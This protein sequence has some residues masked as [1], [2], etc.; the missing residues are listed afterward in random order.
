MLC[1]TR[2][3]TKGRF[4]SSM[5]N[6]KMKKIGL[7]SALMV[8]TAST[9]LTGCGKGNNDTKQ[10]SPTNAAESASNKNDVKKSTDAKPITL[11]IHA[12][13]DDLE[14]KYQLTETYHKSHPNVNFEFQISKDDKAQ[15]LKVK[16]VAGELPDLMFMHSGWLTNLKDYLEPLNDTAAFKQNKFAADFQLDG[17]A[18][19]IPEFSFG[20]YVYYRKS[21]FKEYNLSIPRTWGEFIHTIQVIK[22]GGKYTPY[23]MGA[24]STWPVYAFNENMPLLI[25]GNG[26]LW[27]KM[28][29]EDDPF[30]KDKPFYQASA[31]I[32][33][34]YDMKPFGPDPLGI[35]SDQGKAMFAAGKGAMV[36]FGGWYT[37]QAKSLGADMN[38][39]GVFLMP[40]RD[41]KDE[42]LRAI[43]SVDWFLAT[44]KDGKN[45]QAALDFINWFY[46]NQDGFYQ[47]IIDHD[48]QLSTVKG[49]ELTNNPFKEAYD[50]ITP[51]FVT[52]GME[53]E[54]YSKLAALTKFDR[55]EFGVN[56]IAGKDLDQMSE[57]LNK[58]WKAAREKVSQ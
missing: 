52:I 32:K 49:V 41:S 30:S 35:S 34:L 20:D 37:A 40:V 16:A 24:K 15:D 9:A 3:K 8:L 14:K 50:G 23:I 21:I 39:I 57:D 43:N 28:A 38:D 11:T 18:Y 10:S 13:T 44:P 42:P 5:I 25:S 56:M 53:N 29:S 22:D 27:N 17:K 55:K 36:D 4:N 1:A 2:V 58:Q 31:K 19:G 47:K 51:E 46:T 45:K 12:N 33:K 26:T 48:T 7:I 54:L 6:R